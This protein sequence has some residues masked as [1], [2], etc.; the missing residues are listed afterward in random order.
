MMNKKIKRIFSFL[1]PEKKEKKGG[2]SQLSL[3]QSIQNFFSKPTS[4]QRITILAV[5]A[6]FI[7]HLSIKEGGGVDYFTVF[8]GLLILAFVV[9]WSSLN[10]DLNLKFAGRSIGIIASTVELHRIAYSIAYPEK[11]EESGGAISFQIM[12]ISL[13]L[14]LFL[15][16]LTGK[17]IMSLLKEMLW[18]N[19]K[20]LHPV[21]T[22]IKNNDE[23]SDN[24]RDLDTGT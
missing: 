21:Q 3:L 17:S 5:L 2:G 9:G 14:L 11:L 24:A 10:G 22:T 4:W 19:Q 7:S 15:K 13:M 18:G 6:M 12:G 23:R 8:C 20:Q 1:F 16:C